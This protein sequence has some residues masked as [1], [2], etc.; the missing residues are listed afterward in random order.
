MNEEE[1]HEG[2]SQALIEQFVHHRLPM[3]V[4]MR[5][6]VEAGKKLSDGEIEWLG[7]MLERAH[8]FRKVAYEFPEYQHLIAQVIDTYEE[9]T[10]L[11]LK[12]EGQ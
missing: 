4:Q 6:E 9:I 11:A 8:N 5:D 3:I 12:N 1:E 10:E 7:R 2:I